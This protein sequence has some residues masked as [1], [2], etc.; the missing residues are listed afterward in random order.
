ML[1]KK[2]R[3]NERSTRGSIYYN[4]SE[5]DSDNM[6]DED[7][8]KEDESKAKAD[9]PSLTEDGKPVIQT[10]V[11]ERSSTDLMLNYSPI[12]SER[13][14]GNEERFIPSRTSLR[15]PEGCNLSYPERIH[16]RACVRLL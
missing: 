6:E 5:D 2:Q 10:Q 4:T 14:A 3:H 8:Q 11:E 13:P 9:E 12:R 15:K 1:Q 7:W 16:S